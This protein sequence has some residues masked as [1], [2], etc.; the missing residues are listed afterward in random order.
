MGPKLYSVLFLPG[1]SVRSIDI[2][3]RRGHIYWLERSNRRTLMDSD[4][5]VVR[6]NQD[7]TNVTKIFTT[8]NIKSMAIDWVAGMI[9]CVCICFD[10][11]PA[12]DIF[13]C[14]FVYEKFCILIRISLKF[15]PKGLI[16]NMS[17]LVQVMAWCLTAITWTNDDPVHWRIYAALGGDKL[18]DCGLLTPECTKPLPELLSS[19]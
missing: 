12:E 6:I 17:A 10:S 19:L 16:D 7:G 3:V 14:I 13:R 18:T 2:D 1:N 9:L 8:L 4:F 11:S 5:D 15:V